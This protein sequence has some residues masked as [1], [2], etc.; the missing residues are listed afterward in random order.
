MDRGDWWATV[1]GVTKSQNQLK[2]LSTQDFYGKFS[3]NGKKQKVKRKE[4]CLLC[5]QHCVLFYF[6]F[7]RD[8]GIIIPFYKQRLREVESCL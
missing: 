2:P 8:T 6:I 1:H 3:N 4:K 5:V 7:P